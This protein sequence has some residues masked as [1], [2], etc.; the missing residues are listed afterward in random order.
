MSFVQAKRALP[1]RGTLLP[2]RGRDGAAF[3]AEED[4]AEA[5][6]FSD[7]DEAGACVGAGAASTP[8]SRSRTNWGTPSRYRY[9]ATPNLA[10]AR[11]NA[12]ENPLL[13]SSPWSA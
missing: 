2:S 7:G 11:L 12:S 1:E 10:A 4:G 9:R 13:S 5:W 3:D 6:P 8:G